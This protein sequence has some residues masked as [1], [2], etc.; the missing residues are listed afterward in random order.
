MIQSDITKLIS[1]GV[2]TGLVP[3]EDVIFTT[4][5]LLEL[6]GLEELEEE[7]I[8]RVQVWA[9][10]RACQD[11]SEDARN[12]V[13]AGKQL[14]AGNTVNSGKESEELEAILGRMCDYA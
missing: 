8:Q 4:N 6:F 3:K 12:T 5:S 14:Y 1:Y 7:E 11:M 2:R 13:N 9:E 10:N